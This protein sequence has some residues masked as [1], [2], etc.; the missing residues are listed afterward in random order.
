MGFEAVTMRLGVIGSMIPEMPKRVVMF[1]A[2]S[3]PS[4]IESSR[5]RYRREYVAGHLSDS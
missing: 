1:P 2:V 5:S 3:Y 4:R